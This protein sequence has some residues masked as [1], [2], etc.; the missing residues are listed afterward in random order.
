MRVW[1][2]LAV[3]VALG[4]CVTP[5]QRATQHDTYCRSIGATPGTDGYMRCRLAMVEQL[6]AENENRRRLFLEG[7]DDIE[8][9]AAMMQRAQP[10]RTSCDRTLMGFDCTTY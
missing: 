3:A 2:G 6:R 8:R 10:R 1:I 4:G 7:L 9:G 5:E